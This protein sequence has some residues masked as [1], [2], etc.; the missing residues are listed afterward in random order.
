[1]LSVPFQEDMP[2]QMF[3]YPVNQKAVLPEPFQK[4]AQVP[5]QPAT[6]DPQ[7]IARNRDAWYP[8]CRVFLSAGKRSSREKS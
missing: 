6:L 5:G 4:F 8:L 3:V 1:M 2:L 7:V